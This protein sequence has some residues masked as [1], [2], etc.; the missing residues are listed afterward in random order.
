VGGGSGPLI[1]SPPRRQERQEFAK[2]FSEGF[3]LAFL[4]P[5]RFGLFE[6]A[7]FA[8]IPAAISAIL[9]FFLLKRSSW[10]RSSAWHGNCSLHGNACQGEF[11]MLRKALGFG[12]LALVAG[13]ATPPATN[14]HQ[15]M[16]ARPAPLPE[17]RSTNGAIYQAGTSRMNLFED[18]RARHVGDTLTVVINESNAASSKTNKTDSHNGSA[19]ATLNPNIFASPGSTGTSTSLFSSTAAN[20]A[21]D[22]NQNDN[23]GSFTGTIT[24]TVVEVLPNGNLIVSGEKQV[25]VDHK[26]EYLRVS[27]VVSP[28][29]VTGANTV[30]STQIADARVEYKGEESIDK[31]QLMTMMARF[32]LSVMAF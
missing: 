10:R 23:T 9:S 5:W 28:A 2:V 21:E 27:G 11:T 19:S 26:T 14:V 16:S 22:K 12:L 32:F 24:V 1:F 20:K 7:I 18:R 25:A 13:C 17:A 15:P 4:A 29:Y 30:S 6:A 3:S 31:S 8:A